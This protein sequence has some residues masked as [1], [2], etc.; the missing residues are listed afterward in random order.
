MAGTELGTAGMGAIKETGVKRHVT[1]LDKLSD[2]GLARTFNSVLP[3]KF[4]LQRCLIGF[5]Y[6]IIAYSA[7]VGSR[8]GNTYHICAHSGNVFAARNTVAQPTGILIDKQ[9]AAD[10]V[11]IIFW[12][13]QC[14][15]GGEIPIATPDGIRIVMVMDRLAILIKRNL[16]H[17]AVITGVCTIHI[18]GQSTSQKAMVKAGVELDAAVLGS[19]LNPDTAQLFSPLV[20]C[21]FSRFIK[22]EIFRFCFQIQACILDRGV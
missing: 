14:P 20:L 4:V 11:A 22:S 15:Q 8:H 16:A 5:L 13:S 21:L 2:V 12:V 3:L 1:Q 6:I 19:T 18:A 7:L 10:K 17:S 9:L